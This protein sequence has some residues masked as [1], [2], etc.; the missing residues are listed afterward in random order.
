MRSSLT[1]PSPSKSNHVN[2]SGKL[3][4]VILVKEER[5][6]LQKSAAWLIEPTDRAPPALPLPPGAC[7]AVGG[8]CSSLPGGQS[9]PRPAR[10]WARYL[11]PAELVLLVCL[12]HYDGRFGRPGRRNHSLKFG[13]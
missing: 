1:S 5:L 4:N 9:P 10:V 13:K 8:R 7:H 3:F 2:F 6:P 12:D 11:Y